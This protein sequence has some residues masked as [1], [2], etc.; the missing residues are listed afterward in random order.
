MNLGI[1]L[2]PV[3]FFFLVLGVPVVFGIGL[4]VLSAVFAWKQV[5]MVLIFQQFYQ[6]TDSFPLLAIPLFMLA[7]DLMTRVGIIDDIL[8]F[9]NILVGRFRGGLAYVDIVANVFFAAISG[10]AVADMAAIGTLLTPKME[11]QGYD[12]DFSVSLT[13]AASV[14]GPIIPPSIPMVV[15]SSVMSVSVGAMFL[16]GIIPGILLGAGLAVLSWAIC[17]KRGYK[18]AKRV[19]TGREAL[20]VTIHAIPAL[21]MPVIILG[22]IFSGMF[23][24]TE[25]A[26]ITCLYAI[27]LGRFFYKNLT[28][29]SL[30]ES[31]AASMTSAAGVLLIVAIAKPF[32][33]LVIMSHLA[34]TISAA[35]TTITTSP[36]IMLLI[37]NLILLILG[38]MMEST[39]NILIF[40]PLFAPL[41]ISLGVDPLHFGVIFVL[42]V[43][44]GVATPPFGMCLFIGSNI[45][46]LPVERIMKA[47]LPFVA[48]EI[49]ILLLCTYMPVLVTGLPGLF[50][51]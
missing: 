24:P 12:A 23:S 9:T 1:T 7:G 45:S 21:L 42:N 32:G 22:G 39:A 49:L 29:K 50:G 44:M 35:L 6:G 27:L 51:F 41:A 19:Y 28:W 38:C 4:T 43:M 48:V 8:N 17:R 20:T 26:A 31:F 37:L 13:A 3:M 36:V 11:E 40:A 25:S 30:Y 15:Y 2:I 14:I 46:G 34:D 16:G 18:A 10:S 47:V 5:P 33:W